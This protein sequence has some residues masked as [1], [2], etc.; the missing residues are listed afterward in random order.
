V[1]ALLAETP[2]GQRPEPARQIGRL[3]PRAELV[4]LSV[5]LSVHLVLQFPPL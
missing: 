4:P 5:A 2:R 1:P 3:A